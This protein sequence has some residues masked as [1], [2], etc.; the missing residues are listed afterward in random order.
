MAFFLFKIN[1][2]NY[3]EEIVQIRSTANLLFKVEENLRFIKQL[4]LNHKNFF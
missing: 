1:T 4:I 3:F 2:G